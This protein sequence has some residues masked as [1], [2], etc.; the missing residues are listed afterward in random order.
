MTQRIIAPVELAG[1]RYDLGLGSNMAPS[2]MSL[3]IAASNVGERQLR[4]RRCI[5]AADDDPWGR[6]TRTLLAHHNS[7]RFQQLRPRHFA[8]IARHECIVRFAYI[9]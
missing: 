7:Y 4:I 9:Q 3:A 8:K 2:N 6:N 5:V 1:A